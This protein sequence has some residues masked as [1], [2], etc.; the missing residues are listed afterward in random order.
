MVVTG[1]DH[2]T[3]AGELWNTGFAPGSTVGVQQN[4]IG[5]RCAGVE[6]VVPSVTS[7]NTGDG[8]GEEGAEQEERNRLGHNTHLKLVD[9][10]QH[11]YGVLEVQPNESRFVFRAV[12]K[13]RDDAGVRTSYTLTVPYG[14]PLMEA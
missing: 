9:M 14:T 5:D 12:A 11:G 10:M 2:D 6:F 4:P 13:D 3:Y 1:D 8:A 7:G